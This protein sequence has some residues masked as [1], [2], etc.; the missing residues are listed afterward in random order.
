M[1]SA[2]NCP[3]LPPLW[4]LFAALKDGLSLRGEVDS[5]AGGSPSRSKRSIVSAKKSDQTAR[6]SARATCQQSAAAH[7][8][9]QELLMPMTAEEEVERPKKQAKKRKRLKSDR[10]TEL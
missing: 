2:R 10:N 4:H 5:M 9:Q 1:Y 8:G 3:H 7:I 6:Y